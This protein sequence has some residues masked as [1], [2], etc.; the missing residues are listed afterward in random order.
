MTGIRNLNEYTQVGDLL[1]KLEKYNN[2]LEPQATGCVYWQGPF[3]RQGYGMFSGIRISDGKRIMMTTHRLAMKLKLNRELDLKEFVVHTCGNPQCVNPD[4]LILGDA[5][6][7]YKEM[8][9]QGR[10]GP[11][12]R[13]KHTK[14]HKKQNRQYRYSDDEM[15]W[16]RYATKAEIAARYNVSEERAAT[17]RWSMR[18]NY[19]WLNELDDKYN[20][21]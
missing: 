17:M 5:R 7:R 8:V 16:I 13:G 15:L 4:H 6:L 11:R 9:K 18:T 10:A 1:I 12:I 14:D 21:G 19:R 3:H 20:A 2:K